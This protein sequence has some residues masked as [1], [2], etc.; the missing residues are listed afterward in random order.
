M[1]DN[2]DLAR[3]AVACKHWRWDKATGCSIRHSGL[4]NG[5]PIARLCDI[6]IGG[7]S[8]KDGFNDR[9]LIQTIHHLHTLIEP[10]DVLPD[11]DDAA[12]R[13]CL[14][15]MVRQAY[16]PKPVWTEA[17]TR[18]HGDIPDEWTVHTF[19]GCYASAQIAHGA[20][21]VA[22]LVAALEAAP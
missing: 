9:D 17:D 4:L 10:V 6:V 16:A 1:T 7:Y 20:T 5:K 13:G 12:S 14:L 18:S 3:R 8:K 2:L 11:L 22:A 21:E 15:G 19:D